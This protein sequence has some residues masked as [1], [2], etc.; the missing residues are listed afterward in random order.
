MKLITKSQRMVY[1]KL[2]KFLWC[3]LCTCRNL[4]QCK[5]D[6]SHSVAKAGDIYTLQ[7]AA[8]PWDTHTSATQPVLIAETQVIIG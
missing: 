5:T 6:N 3:I 4:P 1:M 2:V 8:W 7:I